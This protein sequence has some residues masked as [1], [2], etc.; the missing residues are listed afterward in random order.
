MNID[1]ILFDLDNTIYPASSGMMHAIDSRILEFMSDRLGVSPEEAAAIRLEY[2]TTY[3]T[4][5]RGL[6][7]HTSVDPEDFLAHVHD[8]AWDSF[9]E[10]DAELD[11]L[12][13][14][15][16]ATRAIFTNSPAEHARGVLRTLGIERHFAYIFD[17]RF[18]QFLPKP[19][20]AGYRRALEYLG[21]AGQQ[22]IM[23]EDTLKNL[24]TARKLGMATIYIGD[25]LP[26]A[27][28]PAD[29][30]M[31]DVLAALRLILTL[32]DPE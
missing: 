32:E 21:A 8:L 1:A 7:L 11:H 14:Q 16:R 4:T 19:D 26:D 5:L 13:G 31:P 30:V 15:V 29:Y 18:Q 2:F 3:G 23:I 20:E 28:H 6:Q 27:D 17:I 25:A 9:L 12:L 10:S 24:A 22:T